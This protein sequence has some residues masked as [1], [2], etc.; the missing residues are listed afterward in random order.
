MFVQIDEL[1]SMYSRP[2]LSRRSA[3]RPS[4][5]TSGSCSG[6][7]HSRILVNGCQTNRL[8]I[9]ISSSVFHSVITALLLDQFFNRRNVFDG[10]ATSLIF[11]RDNLL[12]PQKILEKG[13]IVISPFSFA[14]N[15]GLERPRAA[16]FGRA[17]FALFS[18]LIFL[19]PYMLTRHRGQ[20]LH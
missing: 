13:K 5:K 4:T 12:Q 18:V 2:R 10:C 11:A 6:A 20:A 19:R 3:P 1:P 15:F 14:G 9:S 16:E 7:H 8:S 17:H